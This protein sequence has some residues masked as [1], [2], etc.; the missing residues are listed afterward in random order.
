[1]EQAEHLELRSQQVRD[2]LSSGKSATLWCAENNIKVSTLRYW[3]NKLKREPSVDESG[4]EVFVE[5]KQQFT[6]KEAPL[7]IKIGDISIEL[8]PGFNTDTL[9]EAITALRAL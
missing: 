6:G 4:H 7:I 3:L 9:R 8:Y 5:F 1:M 2:Y